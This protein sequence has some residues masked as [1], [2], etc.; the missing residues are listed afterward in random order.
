MALD[1]NCT[2]SLYGPPAPAPHP[3]GW[4][5]GSRARTPLQHRKCPKAAA[6]IAYLLRGEDPLG[7]FPQRPTVRPF[8][9]E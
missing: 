8:Q 5:R 6:S 2:V 1:T 4:H 3:L 7:R 9:Y